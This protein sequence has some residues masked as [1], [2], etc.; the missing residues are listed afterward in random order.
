M[1]LR[2]RRGRRPCGAH[3]GPPVRSRH[4]PSPLTPPCGGTCFPSR[5]PG[6]TSNDAPVQLAP[7]HT[8]GG[9]RHALPAPGR[10]RPCPT[11]GRRALD[12]LPEPPGGRTPPRRPHRQ[13]QTH[14]STFS[15]PGSSW[16]GRASRFPSPTNGASRRRPSR[17]PCAPPGPGRQPSRPLTRQT[18]V[19]RP[20]GRSGGRL[21]RPRH[22][23]QIPLAQRFALPQNGLQIRPRARNLRPAPPP[24]ALTLRRPAAPLGSARCCT[25]WTDQPKKLLFSKIYSSTGTAVPT[26]T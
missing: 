25:S 11:G 3:R 26:T 15:P 13:P 5:R 17:R 21:P 20:H 23:A 16:S 6:P 19:P 7:G 10:P 1:R 8:P 14:S 9:T 24:P 12:R 4:P 2:R 18:R 22:L